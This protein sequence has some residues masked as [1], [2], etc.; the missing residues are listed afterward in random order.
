VAADLQ[1]ALKQIYDDQY[2]QIPENVRPSKADF[3]A[4][5]NQEMAP[6]QVP[7][8]QYFI[9][10]DPSIALK[11]VKCPVLVLNGDKDLQVPAGPN[12]TAIKAQLEKA[13]NRRVTVNVLPGLNHLFQESKTGAVEE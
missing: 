1:R 11:S 3:D 13:G 7:W 2:N 10:Y 6:V 5:A 9:R 12:T 8:F 4:A